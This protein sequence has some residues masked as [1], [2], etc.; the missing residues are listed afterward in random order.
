VAPKGAR[1]CHWTH[2][3][4]VAAA[5]PDTTLIPP[6]TR[7][8]ATLSK[9]EKGNPSKYVAFAT[10]CTPLQRLSEYDAHDGHLQAYSR[11]GMRLYFV[12][13]LTPST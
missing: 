3:Q 5:R 6:G 9:P 4:T 2:R 1:A 8:G 12:D 10:L 7:Y 13:S 11:Q